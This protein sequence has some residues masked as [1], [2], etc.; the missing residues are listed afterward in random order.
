[1]AAAFDAIA[2]TYDDV[3]TSSPIGRAQRQAV[4][5]QMDRVFFPGNRI[6]EINCGTGEDAIY[7]ARSGVRVL[8]CDASPRM[9]QVAQ[10]KA[11]RLCDRIRPQFL[12]LEIEQLRSLNAEAEFDGVLSNFSG[13]NCVRDLS[14]AAL[15]LARLARPG[16]TAL[17]C[18]FGRN[19]AWE[20]AWY[21]AHGHPRKAFRRW[22]SRDTASLDGASTVTVFYPSVR[23]VER[24]F[25]PWFQ[26][27]SV[28]G[29]GVFVPPTFADRIARKHPRL[30]AFAEKLDRVVSSLSIF[31]SLADHIL[32]VFE[33]TA[34]IP[35]SRTA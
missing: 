18:L 35:E 25:A 16:S 7:L 1:M 4:W 2:A 33:R 22:R 15:D 6:L 23:R 27:R 14:V 12:R 31:R 28:Q 21:L 30:L 10:A 8:A 9:I 29:I 26:L 19:C 32:F 3:F 17:F 11:A 24:E 5:Q 13:L 34:E 20:I